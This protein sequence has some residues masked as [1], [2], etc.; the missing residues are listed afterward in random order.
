MVWGT[1]FLGP[2][3]GIS[4]SSASRPT[5]GLLLH[6][7]DTDTGLGVLAHKRG[8]GRR[9]LRL[10]L[11]LVRAGW[12]LP[13]LGAQGRQRAPASPPCQQLSPFPLG[14]GWRGRLSPWSRGWR[15]KPIPLAQPWPPSLPGRTLGHGCTGQRELSSR[16][17]S[18]VQISEKQVI[19]QYK[20]FPCSI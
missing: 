4:V 14:S 5:P 10:D 3:G 18:Y 8:R 1:C 11:V 12:A 6:A 9:L 16:A 19:F 15:K 2:C 17:P 20:Y 13:A 7:W